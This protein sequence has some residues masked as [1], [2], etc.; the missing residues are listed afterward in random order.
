MPSHLKRLEE[1]EAF[2]SGQTLI[3]ASHFANTF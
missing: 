2:I 1:I 3:V